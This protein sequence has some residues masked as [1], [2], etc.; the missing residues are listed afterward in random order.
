MIRTVIVPS[1]I[2]SLTPASAPNASTNP[3]VNSTAVS[4]CRSTGTVISSMSLPFAAPSSGRP[5]RPSPPLLVFGSPDLGSPDLDPPAWALRTWPRP[6]HACHR[7]SSPAATSTPGPAPTRVAPTANL[8]HRVAPTAGSRVAPTVA[9]SSGATL[10]LAATTVSGLLPRDRLQPDANPRLG[11]AEPAEQ[12]GPGL[13]DDL[14]L[15]VLFVNPEL[16]ERRVDGFGDRPPSCLH[17]LHL[18]LS[19]SVVLAPRRGAAAAGG[20][21][22][23]RSGRGLLGPRRSGSSMPAWS[24][25]RTP[26]PASPR[27]W[28]EACRCR[29]PA[30]LPPRPSPAPGS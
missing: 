14:V 25:R 29:S 13:L 3:V 16:I 19:L 1:S 30:S 22:V 15:D 8:A 21:A 23:A 6:V 24:R 5:R 26:W 17:P 9:V 2:S 12:P 7:T 20:R 11:S 18:A 4:A 28:V 10:R 27:P